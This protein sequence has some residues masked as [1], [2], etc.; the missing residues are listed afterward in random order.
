MKE[1]L[2]RITNKTRNEHRNMDSILLQHY[3]V[4]NREIKP[5][6]TFITYIREDYI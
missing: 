2:A 1:T 5:R 6:I 4:Q 3:N